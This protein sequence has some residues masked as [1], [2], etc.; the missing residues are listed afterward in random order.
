M[1]IGKNI[2]QLRINKNLT[3]KE[4]AEKLNV[5]YQGIS[6]WEN[7]E[8]EPS[9]DTLTQMAQV[10]ECSLDEIFGTKPIEK[11]KPQVIEKVIIKESE[12]KII[13][14][15]VEKESKPVLAVCE[16]CNNPIFEADGLH[17]IEVPV[18]IRNG[19]TTHKEI[20]TSILCTDC[21]NQRLKEEQ[22]KKDAE[23]KERKDGILSRRKKSFIISSIF[24]ALFVILSIS[25]F[26]KADFASGI[27]GLIFA[28]MIFAF[29]SCIVLNN[30]FL[31][32][33]WLEMASWGFVKFPG[34]IFEFSIDGLIFLIAIK[35]LFWVLGI[36]IGLF[37]VA[38][39]TF[40]YFILSIFVYPFAL[41]RNLNFIS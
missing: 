30:T 29:V 11:P 2:K 39:A 34:V 35:A 22:E 40:V 13:E 33:M 38:L 36:L 6:R 10:F 15:V 32:E 19:R 12:P 17:R 14:K 24:S 16:K 4:L 7:D 25:S 18:T 41:K 26:I 8:V 31:N 1:A 21:N 3:Q 23:E 9:I 20:K 37:C 27:V 5:T 28:F